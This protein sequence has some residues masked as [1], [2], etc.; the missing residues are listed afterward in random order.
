[1]PSSLQDLSL[2][3]PYGLRNIAWFFYDC[4]RLAMAL[5]AHIAS[6]QWQVFQYSFSVLILW[7]SM[8]FADSLRAGTSELW[9]EAVQG[10]CSAWIVLILKS[11]RRLLCYCLAYPHAWVKEFYY[12]QL[13]YMDIL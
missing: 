3:V 8:H 13:P 2:E 7:V 9:K 10:P 6:G 12:F 4:G 11:L 5:G 1:M